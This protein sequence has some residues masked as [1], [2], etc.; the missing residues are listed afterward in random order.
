VPK[1]MPP[2]PPF[3]KA[4]YQG[5]PQKPKAVV[6]HGTVSSDDKGTARNIA[7][8][9]AGPTSPMSSAH[10]V[11]DAHEVIQCVG[12]HRI[13]YHCG[14]NKDSIGY[15][16]CDEQKGP[17]SRWQDEDS[18][19][20]L[21]GAARD[22][23]KLCLAYDIEPR[24][25]SIADLKA[26]G[27]HGIYSHNDSRLAF[28]GTTHTDPRDFPWAQFMRLVRREIKRLKAEAE[29]PVT[30]AP[31]PKP[32]KLHLMQAS[33]LYS[34]S[35]GR[36]EDDLE[37]IFARA[38]RR[39]VTTV[40]GT[41]FADDASRALLKKVARSYGYRV[42]HNRGRDDVW[43]AIRRDFI[44]GKVEVEWDLVVPKEEGFG[45]KGPRG[46]LQVHLED[47]EIGPVTFAEAHLLTKGRPDGG[48]FYR[49]NLPLNRRFTRAIGAAARKAGK[50][51]G[52]FFYLGDQ[53]IV[54]REND[55]FLG[56]PLT[57]SWDELEK[58]ENTGHGNIDVI[59]SY[60]KDG[61]VS[62]AYC[63]ALDDGEFHLHGDHFLVE[64]G[65]WIKGR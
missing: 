47:S 61:K 41:E 22:V 18:L 40:G 55:T 14:Y 50:G 53:N 3:I 65:F 37:K 10:Y 17:K 1:F 54:D 60:D 30:L 33:M 44:K 21:R 48:E 19:A 20:I 11:R 34:L 39:D 63:R 9:W 51:K 7:N 24:R 46:L 32:Y 56:A 45:K 38:A 59:A 62:A 4:R 36:K 8:W 52:L 25:P 12:D 16:F 13:A 26:K 58:W 35:L 27:P 43:L 57:S 23:A 31:Q 29:T 42:F 28:G 2:S 5:G 49:Q 15:E 6:L 64:S